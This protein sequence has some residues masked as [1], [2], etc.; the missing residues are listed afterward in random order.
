MFDVTTG[1]SQQVAQH[2]AP[3]KAV[4]WIDAQGGI[5]ATGSWD[6]TVKVRGVVRFPEFWLNW[7]GRVVLGPSD[8]EPR[9][10]SAVTRALLQ[11]GCA[12]PPD[13]RW[14][15]R[16]AHPDFQPYQPHRCLQSKSALFIL[17]SSTDL[18]VH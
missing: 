2:D 9:I 7:I 8:A 1:Q 17:T 12:V 6:K 4:R 14:H 13:G 11:H 10:N 15:C 18:S 5:L 3:V 16:T